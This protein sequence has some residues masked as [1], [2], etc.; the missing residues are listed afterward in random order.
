MNPIIIIL[1]YS[2]FLK[3]YILCINCHS[4]Y[5]YWKTL[6]PKPDKKAVVLQ[7]IVKICF[8]CFE[9]ISLQWVAN[10]ANLGEMYSGNLIIKILHI[11]SIKTVFIV[12]NVILDIF[13]SVKFH[14]GVDRVIFWVCYASFLTSQ[15]HFPTVTELR[16]CCEMGYILFWCIIKVMWLKSS[17]GFHDHWFNFL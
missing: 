1:K 13:T 4:T 16:Q 5:K 17:N 12:I 10:E 15:C 11:L 14:F 2:Q 9:A 6:F 3:S 7:V 8:I